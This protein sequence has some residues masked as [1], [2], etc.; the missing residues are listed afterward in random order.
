[1]SGNNL[2]ARWIEVDA[3]LYRIDFLNPTKPGFPLG[4]REQHVLFGSL[5]EGR[6]V[7]DLNS[8]SGGFA[9]QAMAHDA[10]SSL[11]VDSSD[12]FAKAISANAQRNGLQ[13]E[14]LASDPLSF[15]KSQSAHAFDAIAVSLSAANAGTLNEICE[16]AFRILPDSGLLAVYLVEGSETTSSVEDAISEAAGTVGRE[17]RVFARTAQP[18]D[19]PML[20]RF[21][22]SL[23]I[24]GI[25]LEVL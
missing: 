21:P 4:L 6:R 19:Y 22:E 14:V 17:A 8:V 7:L 13:V 10:I 23:V 20:L 25:L 11:A 5:C 12:S 16:S 24:E 1:M 9:L 15:L 3:L 2:K 18:F